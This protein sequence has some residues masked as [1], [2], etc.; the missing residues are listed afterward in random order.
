MTYTGQGGGRF[1]DRR[2]I[3]VD[4]AAALVAAGSDREILPEDFVSRPAAHPLCYR[5]C[6]ALRSGQELV[7]FTRLAGREEV[8]AL[9]ADGYLIRPGETA[10]FFRRAVGGLYARGERR[11]DAALRDLLGRVYPPRP[12][13][14]FERQRAAES[15]VR[16]VY[17]HA[18]MD[19]D[20]FDCS[21]ACQCPDLV[22]SADGRLVPA[23]TYNLFYR[24][25]DERF[26]APP[27]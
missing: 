10:E 24:M 23:C 6:Y 14:V 9:L 17:V 2:H 3:P 20:T 27:E 25:E 26:Y 18:H 1:P 13:G 5:V 4:E 16:T 21:R 11:Y 7:P 8:E 15:A 19:E 12:L 22:A